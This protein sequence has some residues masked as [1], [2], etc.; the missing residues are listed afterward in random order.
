VAHVEACRRH[1]VDQVLRSPG[2][3]DRAG[4]IAASVFVNKFLDRLTVELVT[5]DRGPL[6]QWIDA[7]SSSGEA[8]FHFRWVVLACAML[9]ASY[10]EENGADADVIAFLT[11]RGHE[12][13]KRLERGPLEP[14]GRD[15]IVAAL[16]A[17]LGARD[18]YTAEHS[19]AVGAWC[20]R[21]A[22]A[23]RL[24]SDQQK[25]AETCGVLHDVGKVSTPTEIIMKA[26]PLTEAEWPDMHAH[27]RVGATLLEQIPSLREFAPIVRAHHERVDG[28]GYPDRL[29][30]DQIP[31]A[32]RIVS[33][34]D[35]FH[36]MAGGHHYREALSPREAV[37]ALIAGRGTQFDAGVVDALA[38]LVFLRTG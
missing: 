27:A 34:A 5:A 29:S 23:L 38:E 11:M 33:V 20:R 17:T 25:F 10:V 37:G 32:A 28:K 18:P 36:A 13:G 21:I 30:G 8:S 3:G 9:A 4:S 12:I 15:E 7:A 2:F 19:L 31:L 16:I 35:A 22:S 14:A 26:G 6:D 1:V 24:S